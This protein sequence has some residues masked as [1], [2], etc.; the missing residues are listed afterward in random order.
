MSASS[1]ISCS[2]VKRALSKA[3][4]LSAVLSLSACAH[5]PAPSPVTAKEAPPMTRESSAVRPRLTA[6]QALLRLLEIVRT[7]GT[8]A[9]LTPERLEQVM[10]VPISPLGR[11]HG[12]FEQITPYWSYR[13]SLT[14]SHRISPPNFDITFWP[15]RGID[16][17]PMTDICQID[18]DQFTAELE[19]MGFTRKPY[20]DPI[21]QMDGARASQEAAA[22][23]V[24]L[25]PGPPPLMYD[26]FIRPGMRIEV[27][28]RGESN[29]KVS[30]DCIRSVTIY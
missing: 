14:H 17:P 29:E 23:G 10:E 26:E 3:S 22:L 16:S 13:L 2:V 5:S 1:Q 27:A 12:H 18:Y 8:I 4:L 20:Y 11:G 6:E 30:H 15:A 19:T 24:P 9:D 25:D 21:A 7:S 28:P